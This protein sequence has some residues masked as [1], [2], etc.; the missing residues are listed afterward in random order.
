VSS[1]VTLSANQFF[2]YPVTVTSITYSI[3]FNGTDISNS[4]YTSSVVDNSTVEVQYQINYTY[5][6]VGYETTATSSLSGIE[7]LF[8]NNISIDNTVSYYSSSTIINVWLNGVSVNYDLSA[9]LQTTNATLNGDQSTTMQCNAINGSGGYSYQWWMSTAGGAYSSIS[10]AT[11][12]QY[13]Y[14][15]G[16]S[17]FTSGEQITFYC[18]VT[19]SSGIISQSNVFTVTVGSFSA[20]IAMES[21]YLDISQNVSLYVVVTGGSGNYTYAWEQ[22]LTNINVNSPLYTF[23][24]DVSTTTANFTVTVT[25]TSSSSVITTSTGDI[26]VYSA[27]TTSSTINGSSSNIGFLKA[28]STSVIVLTTTGGSGKFIYAWQDNGS[29]IGNESNTLNYTSSTNGIH[30]IVA[31]ISDAITGNVVLSIPIYITVVGGLTI[32][33]GSSLGSVLNYGSQESIYVNVSGGSGDYSYQWYSNTSDSNTGGTSVSSTA[34]S[35]TFVV[36]ESSPLFYY[37]VVN[38]TNSG[39]L[40]SSSVYSISVSSVQVGTLSAP[41]TSVLEDN[42]ITLSLSVTRGSGSFSYQ[43]FEVDPSGTQSKITA[44]TSYVFD[45]PNTLGVYTFFVLITD[46]NTT[47]AVYSNQ[48]SIE[49]GTFSAEITTSN[50]TVVAGSFI[51]LYV[52]VTGGTYP[53]SY[54]WYITTS[55]ILATTSS[56]STSISETTT[57]SVEVTDATNNRVTP[58]ITITVVP[59]SI[60]ISADQNYAFNETGSLSVSFTS[61]SSVTW[62]QNG[63]STGTT[64]TSYSFSAVGLAVGTYT[65]YGMSGS[66]QT[67]SISINVVSTLDISFNDRV[68][69]IDNTYIV[70]AS[71]SLPNRGQNFTIYISGVA[72]RAYQITMQRNINAASNVTFRVSKND[73]KSLSLGNG[74][75]F[76]YRGNLAFTGIIRTITKYSDY[77]YTVVAYDGLW[78]FAEVIDNVVTGTLTSMITTFASQTSLG[79]AKIQPMQGDT[80][81][82]V[83]FGGKSVMQQVLE[84]LSLLNYNLVVDNENNLL[85]LNYQISNPSVT[86][87][88][89]TIFV[90]SSKEYNVVSNYGSVQV[91]AT[92]DNQSYSAYYGAGTPV[93]NI[94]NNWL[95]LPS[96]T[97]TQLDTFA[98]NV[99]STYSQGQWSVDIITFG[100]YNLAKLDNQNAPYVYNLQFAD[101]TILDNLILTGIQIS[102]GQV[103]LIIETYDD[104][105]LQILNTLVD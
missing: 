70:T 91:Q 21:Q 46:T 17:G 32:S 76:F 88:E 68:E 97:Q 69:P 98:N 4:T 11:S 104:T 75:Q 102:Q 48:L 33:I 30:T 42:S 16:T 100:Y 96:G 19:D 86:L 67:N 43:W 57:Y 60:A 6:Q 77:E 95:S 9:T 39:E 56:Y 92:I 31:I 29:A 90:V 55:N 84:L 18:I 99:G 59:E 79:T 37:C 94:G 72:V 63:T 28:G 52:T 81:F 13:T 26:T 24:P 20:Y 54:Q 58:S 23:I 62:Y 87:V 64:G 73:L 2:P 83:N 74:V 47:T 45:A 89:N 22:N 27:I 12:Y 8:L 51:N 3:S 1:S 101:G 25:D 61:S 5:E 93:R 82:T 66:Y 38:D 105:V 44:T 7:Q 50:T 14:T 80:T 40:A 10:G 15:L 35:Y 71:N 85:L 53:L 36:E 78:D 49:V 41:S 34:P 65:F 103:T